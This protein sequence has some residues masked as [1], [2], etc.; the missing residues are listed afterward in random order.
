[1]KSAAATARPMTR[2]PKTV[3]KG[4]DT[5]KKQFSFEQYKEALKGAGPKLKEIILERA[6]QDNSI[7]F[8]EFKQL[9]D[10]AYPDPWA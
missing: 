9:V 10:L 4:S 8:P 1:M 3:R 2:S 6:N 5:M 7:E